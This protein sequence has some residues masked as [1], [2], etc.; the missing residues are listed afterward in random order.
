MSLIPYPNVPPLPGVPAINRNSAGYVGAALNIA[1]QLLP[2]NLFGTKWAI[3][4][5]S[6]NLAL[7]PDSFVNFEYKN[8]RKIPNYPVEGG[9]FSNYNKVAMPFDCRCVVTCSGNGAMS[10]Q[11]FLLALQNY[12]DSLTLLTISTPDASYPNL[13]LVHVDYRRE[14]K[15][16]ATLLL[17]QLWFQ[18][19]RIAQKSA[20]PETAEPSG[21]ASVDIGQVSPVPPSAAQNKNILSQKD[22]INFGVKNPS[23]GD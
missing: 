12:L 4:D 2:N 18:E 20:A 3:T 19:V 11:G 8:E 15:Q 14:S 9:S 5:A 1:A 21:S 10:K 17:V 16:G 13:N 22:A 23:S 6:G 7:V